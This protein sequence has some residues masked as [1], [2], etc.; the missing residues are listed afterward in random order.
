RIKLLDLPWSSIGLAA[1]EEGAPSYLAPEQLQGA[2]PSVYSD[3]WSLAK[4]LLDILSAGRFRGG[5]AQLPTNLAMTI[6]RAQQPQ[7]GFRFTQMMELVGALRMVRSELSP[8]IPGYGGAYPNYGQMNPLG[9][10]PGMVPSVSPPVSTGMNP[11]LGAPGVGPL[12]VQPPGVQ[13]PVTQPPGVQPPV[14]P[15]HAVGGAGANSAGPHGAFGTS[16]GFGPSPSPHGAQAA[17]S[18]E[19]SLPG[20]PLP[21]GT[22]MPE[23]NAHPT[24]PSLRAPNA[25]LS[26]ISRAPRPLPQEDDPV[27]VPTARPLGTTPSGALP[28]TGEFDKQDMFPDMP[29]PTTQRVPK[30]DP[31]SNGVLESLADADTTA[32]V[33]GSSKSLTNG[34]SP[35]PTNGETVDTPIQPRS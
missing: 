10:V 18:A 13:P 32:P 3:Q 1:P 9:S 29:M 31:V 33:V 12:G 22:P 7:P 19:G 25:S 4:M 11:N 26:N 16:G 23:P 8:S 6:Q 24:L 5:L 35:S 20:T 27:F 17:G 14:G 2:P 30:S 28:E 21:Q 15:N 34:V